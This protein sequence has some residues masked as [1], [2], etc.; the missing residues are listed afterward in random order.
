[1]FV[2]WEDRGPGNGSCCGRGGSN[3]DLCE[4]SLTVTAALVDGLS[5]EG[6]RRL[7]KS[8]VNRLLRRGD[9][10]RVCVSS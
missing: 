8:E 3:N 2:G 4:G 6:N 10:G 1:M 7:L 5:G 9:S